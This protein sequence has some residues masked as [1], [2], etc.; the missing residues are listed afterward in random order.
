MLTCKHS[1]SRGVPGI[2][3]LFCTQ[4]SWV[5]LFFFF[6]SIYFC[7]SIC[8][9]L[10]WKLPC[11]PVNLV[12]AF[13]PRRQAG[14]HPSCLGWEGLWETSGCDMRY[15]NAVATPSGLQDP[16]SGPFQ[17][18][19]HG[20]KEGSWRHF[21]VQPGSISCCSP[22]FFHHFFR[23]MLGCFSFLCTAQPRTGQQGAIFKAFVKLQ[24]NL[25]SSAVPSSPFVVLNSL[26][27]SFP[28]KR[29]AALF[30]DWQL[31]C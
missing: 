15:Q 17:I 4:K 26:H 21:P 18:L 11:A 6:F 13:V 3:S 12:G 25:S 7:L 5:G 22:L 28:C 16:N 23:K 29:R 31:L 1:P 20:G 2:C 30:R 8:F 9:L 19:I 10:L 14:V 24:P 27:P